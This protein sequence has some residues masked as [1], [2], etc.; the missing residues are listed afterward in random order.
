MVALGFDPV[1]LT[2]V[3]TGKVVVAAAVAVVVVVE[4][5]VAVV[6]VSSGRRFLKTCLQVCLSVCLSACLEQ[7]DRFFIKVYIVV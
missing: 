3:T 1:D 7:L 4:V 2:W 6:E 5:A